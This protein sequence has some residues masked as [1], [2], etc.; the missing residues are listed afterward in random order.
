MKKLSAK[1]ATRLARN[2]PLSVRWSEED[3]SFIGSIPGLVGECCHGETPEKVVTQLRDIAEDIVTHLHAKGEPLP[4][5]R[6]PAA[7]L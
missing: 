3:Q 1:E 5:P 2:Y 7:S 6:L 4:P